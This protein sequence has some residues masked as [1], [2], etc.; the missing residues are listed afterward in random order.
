MS[1]HVVHL[2]YTSC[3]HQSQLK[4][5]IQHLLWLHTL[6]DKAIE[7]RSVLLLIRVFTKVQTL[8]GS[9]VCKNALPLSYP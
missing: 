1:Q 6:C 3:I 5:G 9:T 7:I 8:P 4:Y 2:V